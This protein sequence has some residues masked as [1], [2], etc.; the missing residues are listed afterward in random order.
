MSVDTGED[1]FDF[2]PELDYEH[3]ATMDPE[4]VGDDEENDFLSNRRP[5]WQVYALSYFF[6]AGVMFV[7][8][9]WPGSNND[10]LQTVGPA[11]QSAESSISP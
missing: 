8:Y 7:L 3:E 2:D 6:V 5:P 10:R 1:R 11:T 4:V 9:V